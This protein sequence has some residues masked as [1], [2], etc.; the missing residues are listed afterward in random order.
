MCIGHLGNLKEPGTF[1]AGS[2]MSMPYVVTRSFDNKIN[3]FHNV[4]MRRALQCCSKAFALG[5]V[6]CAAVGL[7]HNTSLACNRFA[8]TMQQQWPQEVALWIA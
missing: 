5:I 6:I 4:R 8:D 1:T 7:A 3:A 2:Y